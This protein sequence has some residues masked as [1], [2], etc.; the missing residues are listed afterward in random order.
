MLLFVPFREESCLI[1]ENE[2]AEQAFN[3]LL[4]GDSNCSGHH[5]RLQTML[6][7]KV[8]VT[9]INK[10]RNADGVEEKIDTADDDQPQLLGEAKCA[11]KDVADMAVKQTSTQSLEERMAM[12]NVDQRR[13]FDNIKAH[14][15]HQEQHDSK[16]CSCDF[17][18]PR[19]FVSGVGGTGKSFLIETI[20]QLTSEICPS[21]GTMCAIAAPTGLAAFIVV[22]MTIHRLF[23][24]PIEREGK[25]SMYW[26]LPKASHKVMK[27]TL[28]DMKLLIV[29]EVSMVSSLTLAYIH[30]RLEEIFGEQDWFGSKN[31]L[32]V[33]DLLQL[34]PVN[35]QPVFEKVS[36]KAVTLKLGCATS[37]NIWR[38][39]VVYDELTIN[40]RQSND[41]EFST[42]LDS[43]WRGYPT[44]DDLNTLQKGVFSMPVA[45]KFA[46]L[47]RCGQTP[48]CLFPKRKACAVPST[49]KCFLVYPRRYILLCVPMKLTKP[50]AHISGA[51]KLPTSYKSS[52]MTAIE[53][54]GWKPNLNSP[55][56]HVRCCV[57]ILTL[58]L[59]W[60][61]L[62][63]LL[64][65]CD[66]S[67]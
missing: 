1:E 58:R 48:V 61:C 15:L 21:G 53:R 18:P 60:H 2:T 52:T 41:L 38:D 25:T 30:L 67:V 29:D 57:G 6:A 20:D 56:V 62:L 43:M 36:S 45:D 26:P 54:P 50:R 12:L 51:R 64:K 5:S 10:A 55:W 3:R 17:T 37:V 9:A 22:G 65:L 39:T 34:Q 47:Q 11:M 35:G 31:V 49:V 46:E 32:F 23:Q 33:R 66:R 14:P 63:C 24:L 27:T 42:M 28:R 4:P 13:V 16:S 19:M 59:D 40:E 7:A 8:S 44:D